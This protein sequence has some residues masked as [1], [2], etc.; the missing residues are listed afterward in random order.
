MI[1]TVSC[2]LKKKKEKKE[3]RNGTKIEHVPDYSDQDEIVT[4]K[5]SRNE[6]FCLGP[7]SI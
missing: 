4:K 2:F 7:K 6:M 1:N 5:K 3:K